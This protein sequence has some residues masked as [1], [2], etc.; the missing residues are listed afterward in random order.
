MSL[1]AS[2][3]ARVSLAFVLVAVLC[4][5]F[6]DLGVTTLDPWTTLGQMASGL[7]TPSLTTVAAPV[8]AVAM[9]VAFALW[10]VVIAAA[11]GFAL[12]S[13][14]HV[15][16][17]RGVCAF[18][19]SIHELFWA[20]IFLQIFGLHPL[21]G[22]LA[23]SIPYAGIF[24]KVYSEILEETDAA[25]S[26]WSPPGSS[27][28]SVFL[29]ARLPDAWPHIRQYTAYRTECALRSS[30]V[31]G[32]IGIPTL[33]YYLHSAFMQGL[34]SDAGGLLLLFFALI[35]LLRWWLKAYLLPVYLAG[36]LL[37][38][39]DGLPMATAG[40]NFWRFITSDIVPAPLREG[41]FANFPAWLAELAS[42][43]I[44]PGVVNTLLLTQIAL[45]GCGLLAMLLFPMVSRYLS[46]TLTR[47]GGHLLLVIFRSIPEYILAF[48][49]LHAF[50]PSMLPAA[51]ALALHN[52]AIIAY[53]IG[54][55]SNELVLRAD[56]GRGLN[57]YAFELTPRLYGQ[58]LAFLFYRWEIIFRETAIVGILGVQTLGFFVD[59]AMQALKFDQAFALILVTG[60]L[61]LGIDAVSRV[62]R[63]SL[64]L[65]RASDCGPVAAYR[66][67]DGDEHKRSGSN[68]AVQPTASVNT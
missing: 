17:V 2:P 12:A 64:R 4:V 59:N 30:A 1:L 10:G 52:G 39:F 65:S 68:M 40:A 42:Q 58:F 15:V 60:F 31:L 8:E 53:L 47:G 18:L 7:L 29:F 21:T 36:G 48:I 50:G 62:I 25:A 51:L 63:R 3:A 33:G 67:N 46:G 6:A 55:H 27:A 32:F 24:A 13:V 61:N 57:P 26:R 23:I 19:R 34:Y 16:W 66:P 37:L 22:L 9:T 45:V 14:F 49:F 43:S 11:A 28:M 5:P 38:L 20:L 41:Q 54:R 44:W 35:G 56:R